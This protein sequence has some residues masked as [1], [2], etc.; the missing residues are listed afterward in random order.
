M[1]KSHIILA[2]AILYLLIM[3]IGGMA[4]YA[5]SV[6]HEQQQA[7]IEQEAQQEIDARRQAREA[8][9][10]AREAKD[11]GEKPRK[12]AARRERAAGE[13]WEETINGVTYY[14]HH[15]PK[16][17]PTGVYLRPFVA[18][19][20]DRCVLKNDIYYYYSITDAEQTAWI[21][22]DRL[23][24]YA[25]GQTTTL[26]LDPSELRKH[27][28]SDASWLSENYVMNADAATLAA[29]RQIIAAG[30]ATLVYYKEGG[31]SR[32]HDMSA[33]EIQ[34]IREM[35]ELYDALRQE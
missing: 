8:A 12:A 28:S 26:Q 2:A 24:I 17:L 4:Y 14:K 23:D 13:M 6:Q 34:N 30:A 31:K 29:F 32:R 20:N 1:K 15:W 27:M 33:Q 21:M 11:E 35:V 3:V 18:A 5:Y 19:Q 16:K 9:D 7:K 10:K 22:G 25:G